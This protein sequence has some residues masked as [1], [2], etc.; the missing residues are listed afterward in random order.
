MSQEVCK[1][2]GSVGYNPNI[3][4]LEGYN[5]LIRSLPGPGTSLRSS[6]Y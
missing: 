5:P 1:R 4:H 6:Y 3:P 2:L